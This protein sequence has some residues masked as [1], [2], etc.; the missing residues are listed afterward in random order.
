MNRR[1]K[2]ATYQVGHW[3]L[4]HR[5][6]FKAWPCNTLDSPYFGTF[7]VTDVAEGSMWI[8]TEP[9]YGGLAEVGYAQLKH[10]DVL[11]AGAA[12]RVTSSGKP[13]HQS[14]DLQTWCT[15]L[16]ARPRP[17]ASCLGLNGY[18]H[19]SAQPSCEL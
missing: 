19:C 1:R 5:T 12:V 8:K 16:V 7:L 6:R 13:H 4:V 14:Q 15:G 18:C 9:K 10:Y 2:E 17:R 11:P 3:V